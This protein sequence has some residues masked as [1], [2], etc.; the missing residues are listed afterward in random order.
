MDA[1][2][3]IGLERFDEAE[4]L[5]RGELRRAQAA[6][7]G[8]GASL[9]LEG[10]GVVA[11]R[12]GHEE[13]ALELMRQA[14]EAADWPDPTQR[15][16]L[17]YELAR[18]M[19]GAGDAGGAVQLLESCLARVREEHAE[20]SRAQARYAITL[21]Y[22]HADAGQY[23]SAATLLGEVMRE[24]GEDI[25]LPMR[26]TVYYALARLHNSTGQ[27]ELALGYAR[28]ALELRC[29]TGEEWYEGNCHVQ[30][31][32]LLLTA[33]QTAE[34][35]GHLSR[36]RQLY[37][38]RMST[39]DEGYLKV[40]EARLALQQSEPNKAAEIARD[41]IELL[42]SAAVPGEL[43][44]ANLVLARAYEEQGEDDRADAAYASAIQ[45]F[46]R[47]NGW[48]FERARAYRL[49]GKYLRRQGR[50][51]AALDAFEQAADLAPANQ[52]AFGPDRSTPGGSSG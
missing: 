11:S 13:Q 25:D 17:Y 41:A 33:G 50:T 18:L 15:H 27:L 22:A 16:D 32:N 34:A 7:D 38:D 43:G 5:L 19:S 35:A 4:E 36:A 42:S 2:L 3:L 48:P 51:E 20:D 14:V 6:G 26:A 28:Q 44:Q 12:R 9:A 40:D 29:Q 45:L 49:Y 10:L 8:S 37:G 47:Q 52:A 23:A 21:S 31:A 24:G 1:E 30:V 39:I 46:R